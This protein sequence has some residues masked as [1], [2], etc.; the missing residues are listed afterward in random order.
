MAW[1][2]LSPDERELLHLLR[3]VA[4]II[5]QTAAGRRDPDTYIVEAVAAAARQFAV[6]EDYP[7]AYV[8]ALLHQV[9]RIR[10]H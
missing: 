2:D 7:A 4:T 6:D 9:H 1:Q 3:R 8:A 10:M 5:A